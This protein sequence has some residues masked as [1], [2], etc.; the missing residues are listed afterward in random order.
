MPVSRRDNGIPA[1]I[2]VLF[3]DPSYN[4]VGRISLLTGFPDVLGVAAS[5]EL[6]AIPDALQ[7][8]LRETRMQI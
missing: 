4:V 7:T 3:P 5:P 8:K 2:D 6:E 1:F